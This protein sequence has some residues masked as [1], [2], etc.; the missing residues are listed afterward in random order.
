MNLFALPYFNK[1]DIDNVKDYYKVQIL[2]NNN[3]LDIDLNFQKQTIYQEEIYQT[4]IFLE[5][6]SPV[7]QSN[8]THYKADFNNGG[9]T[10]SYINCYFEEL[11]PLIDQRQDMSLQ[12]KALLDKLDLIRVGLYPDGKYDSSFFAVF[13]YSIRLDDEYCN[14][15]LV[16]NTDANGELV[17]I[18]WES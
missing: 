3:Q 10:V 15:L 16:V 5:K 7:D 13:D 17:E 2:Y 14:Q 9:E 6:I 1:I 11:A 8:R 12:Q 4:A 18:T